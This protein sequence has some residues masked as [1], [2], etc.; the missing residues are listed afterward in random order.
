MLMKK[1]F[2]LLTKAYLMT[3]Y[4]FFFIIITIAI[5]NFKRE[6]KNLLFWYTILYIF[7]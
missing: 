1:E 2:H 3:R 6:D 7:I 4:L 5:K